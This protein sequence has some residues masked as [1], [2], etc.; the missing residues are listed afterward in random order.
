LPSR[1]GYP[2]ALKVTKVFVVGKR[3]KKA[4]ERKVRKSEPV[5]KQ[6]KFQITSGLKKEDV[7]NLP[8]CGLESLDLLE[9]LL[10]ITNTN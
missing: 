1:I 2:G 4:E 10:K 5:L 7:S 8:R 3:C 9:S 6:V